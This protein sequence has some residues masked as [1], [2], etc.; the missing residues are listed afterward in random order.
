M[1]GEREVRDQRDAAPAKVSSSDQ[2]ASLLVKPSAT[3]SPSEVQ[4][5][6]QFPADRLPVRQAKVRC[7]TGGLHTF[8][9]AGAD[10]GGVGAQSECQRSHPTLSLFHPRVVS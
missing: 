9:G 1:L 3:K 8:V 4:V 2:G 6:G 5:P 7:R 10:F